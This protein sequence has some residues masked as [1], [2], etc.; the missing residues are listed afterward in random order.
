MERGGVWTE[1]YGGRVLKVR[2]N[3][4]ICPVLCVN[5]CT[6]KVWEGWGGFVWGRRKRVCVWGRV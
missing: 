6:E 1:L 3:M 5:V 4:G 2:I